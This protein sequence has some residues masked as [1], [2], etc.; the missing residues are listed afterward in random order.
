[1][2]IDTPSAGHCPQGSGHAW[3]VLKGRA[4][5]DITGRSFHGYEWDWQCSKC[6]AIKTQHRLHKDAACLIR[7][8]IIDGKG[9]AIE[10][11]QERIA[12]LNAQTTRAQ[13]G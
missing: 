2:T 9:Y 10:G 4:N 6:Q 12:R 11:Y 5:H 3:K 7:A 8:G 1:M 13:E